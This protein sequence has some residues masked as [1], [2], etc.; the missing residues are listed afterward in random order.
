M[1]IVTQFAQYCRNHVCY[2]MGMEEI[3]CP[4]CGGRLFVHGT[5]R[6][7]MK[8]ETEQVREL[9]LR[10]LECEACGRTHRELPD[11]LVPYR[12]YSAKAICAMAET[13]E[14]CAA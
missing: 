9:R 4:A 7:R 8:D 13:P 11:L 10:V 3:S 5:C 1:V 14:R 6:R 2:I 12:R